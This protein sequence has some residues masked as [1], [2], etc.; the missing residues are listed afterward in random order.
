VSGSFNV[1][2]YLNKLLTFLAFSTASRI[3]IAQVLG[4]YVLKKKSF[5]G[6]KKRH[7]HLS[8]FLKMP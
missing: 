2:I 5:V 1:I 4:L 6:L 7:L 3:A 8:L